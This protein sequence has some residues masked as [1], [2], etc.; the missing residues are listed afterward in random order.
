MRS[1]TPD[2]SDPVDLPP[3]L[4]RLADALAWPLMLLDGAGRLQ[5][6]NRAARALLAA[7][8]P[9]QRAAGQPVQPSAEAQ[10]PAFAAAVHDAA[11]GITSTLC[12]PGTAG[13]CAVTLNPLGR[14]SGAPARCLLTV[15]PTRAWRP[16]LAAFAQ[17]LALSAAET[18]VLQALAHGEDTARTVAALGLTAGTVRGHVAALRRKSG[19]PT[20]AALVQALA[21][22]PP[23]VGAAADGE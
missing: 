9:L 11:G 4:A 1:A 17:E 19:H 18:R 10:R 5:H 12:W 23:A 22:L 21:R 16:D 13:L 20:V 6:A 15:A 2:P 14:P 8:E 3:A 7:G